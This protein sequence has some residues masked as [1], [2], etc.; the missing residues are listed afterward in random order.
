M[1]V[2]MERILQVKGKVYS[3]DELCEK[4]GSDANTNFVDI[5]N[6]ILNE[7]T[8]LKPFKAQVRSQIL[9]WQR[10]QLNKT[11]EDEQE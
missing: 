1:I 2:S 11:E 9:S 5:L 8:D 4:Y 10:E 3:I 6:N 7:C